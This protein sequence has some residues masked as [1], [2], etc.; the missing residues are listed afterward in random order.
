MTLPQM[1]RLTAPKSWLK[2]WVELNGRLG[3]LNFI[4]CSDLLLALNSN[5]SKDD[6][7]FHLYS[8]RAA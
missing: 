1:S 4:I 2:S 7:H 3:R 6:Y 8:K 5:Y